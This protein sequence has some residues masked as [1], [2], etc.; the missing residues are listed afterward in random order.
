MKEKGRQSN[1][2]EEDRKERSSMR[3][4]AWA[5]SRWIPEFSFI[6]FALELLPG[7]HQ[8]TIFP[9]KRPHTQQNQLACGAEACPRLRP[10]ETMYIMPE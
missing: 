5:I 1:G 10:E 9:P 8:F 6:T 4:E 2:Q 7:H 3:L